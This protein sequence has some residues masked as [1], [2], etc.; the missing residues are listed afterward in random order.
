[1]YETREKQINNKEEFKFM[2]RYRNYIKR[3]IRPVDAKQT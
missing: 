1:M 2:Y 3:S